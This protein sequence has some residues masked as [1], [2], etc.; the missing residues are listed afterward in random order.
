ME[1]SDMRDLL[2]QLCGAAGVNGLTEIQ[3]VAYEML[4][5]YANITRIDANGNVR[6]TLCCEKE[7]A[8]RVLLEAHMDEIGFVVTGFTE[9]GFVRVAPCGGVD[10]RCVAAAPVRIFGKETVNGVFCAVPPHLRGDTDDKKCQPADKL[11][12]DVG[13]TD[14]QSCISVGD[15]VSFMP[16]YAELNDTLISAKALDDRAGMAAVMYALSLLHGRDLSCDVEV[17]FACGEELGSRGATPAAFAIDADAAIVTDVSF[18]FT[19]DAPRESCGDLGKGA[20]IGISPILDAQFSKRLMQYAK[21]HDIPFQTEVM[22]G[23]TGTDADA[24]TVAGDGTPSA[25]LSIPQRYMHT[26]V[27]VVDVRD[28]AAVGELIAAFITEEMYGK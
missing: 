21:E 2:Q 13:M 18:A 3:S 14:P 17:L 1:K 10:R 4:K 6:A 12:V 9:S 23:K 16:C 8:K 11:F 7:N 25:L 20:M 24:V 5:E 22:G 28:V 19:P 27:E 26:P 15:R